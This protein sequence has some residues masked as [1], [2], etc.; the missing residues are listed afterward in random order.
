MFERDRDFIA[1]K[2]HKESEP[3]DAFNRMAYHG[4]DY[5]PETGMT[6]AEIID[7]LKKLDFGGLSHPEI[8]AKAVSYVLDNTRIDVNDRDYYVGFYSLNRLANSVTLNVWREELFGGALRREAE[9]MQKMNDS[10]AVAIW[11]DFDHVVPDWKSVLSLGFR[12]IKERAEK[13]KGLHA[14]NGTLDEDARALFDGIITLYDAIIRVVDRLYRLAEA[15][16]TEKSEKLPLIAQCLKNIRDAAPANFYEATQV[17]FIYFIVS[18]C[19]DSYQ[20]R[21]LGNGL[22]G[23]LYPFY[24]RDLKNGTFTKEEMGEFLK[25]FMFQWSAIGNYWGQPFYLGGTKKNGETKYNELSYLVL[26]VYDEIGIYNPKIQ[27]KINENTP[28]KLL[29]KACDMI[30]RGHNSIV[31]CCEPGMTKAIMAY[32]ATADEARES[33]IRGCYETGVRANE[34]SSATGYVNAAKAVEYVFSNGYD[35]IIGKDFGLKTGALSEFKTFD[36]FYFAVIR[37]WRALIEKTIEVANG[38]EKY[39]SVINPSLTYTATIEYALGRGR[40]AYQNGVK[41]NNSSVLNCGFATLV[42]SV[43][44]VKKL[45]YDD[46]IVSLEELK[47]AIDNDWKGYESLR[48]KAQAAPKYG[49]GDEAADEIAFSLASYYEKAVNG[50]PN[51]RGG[52]YKAIMHTAMQFKWA[53]AKTAATPDGRRKGEEIGK[54][55]S[56][57]AGADREGVTAI[58]TSALRTKPYTYCESYGLDVWIHPSACEGSDGLT[59]MKG[60]LKTYMRGDGQSIQFNVLSADTLRDAQVHPEKYKNLQVRVCGWN[61]L[62][63]NLPREEQDE[64]I[65]RAEAKE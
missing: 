36:D 3:F 46:K 31:F 37:Q 51:A 52:V 54:N 9:K 14:E 19:F 41:F 48:R 43:A 63:N 17:I 34:V 42:D 35:G 22:D 29:D 10:G 5:D 20:V 44:A 57:S 8:K 23:S 58:I 60:L 27:L 33:D 7:G 21:S 26:D 45:V 15:R 30:R 12:R 62:W 56:P 2:Y 6:D 32:G 39:F 61:V 25:Y 16:I 24:E 65:L 13:Y 18:E 53:G 59:A 50:R 47:N 28:E 1:N 64:Y 40:D 11:P 49:N 55:G 38:Y 4:Y